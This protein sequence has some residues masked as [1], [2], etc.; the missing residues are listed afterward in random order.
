MGILELATLLNNAGTAAGDIGTLIADKAQ[1]LTD[2]YGDMRM[3]LADQMGATQ[4]MVDPGDAS[5][6]KVID[7]D[8]FGKRMGNFADTA[9]SMRPQMPAVPQGLQM[10]Q[11]QMNPM[12]QMQQPAVNPYAPVNYGTMSQQPQMGGIGSVP[13]MEQILRALQSQQR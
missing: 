11:G 12:P 2:A 9:A 1:P 5:E 8:N 6:Y 13:S 10:P 7:E 3:K 4:T